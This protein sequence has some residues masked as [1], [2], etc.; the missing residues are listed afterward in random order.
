MRWIAACTFLHLPSPVQAGDERIEIPC[1]YVPGEIHHYRYVEESVDERRTGTK[2]RTTQTDVTIEVQ[3]YDGTM[4]V[5]HA[6]YGPPTEL[7][8]D[9]NLPDAVTAAFARAV[10]ERP[11]V[12]HYETN[13]GTNGHEIL[14][15]D[16]LVQATL[17]IVD[18][19]WNEMKTKV[20]S[21]PD[22]VREGMVL[23]ATPA[24][25]AKSINEDLAPLFD[26]S[27]GSFFRRRTYESVL[28]NFLGGDPFPARGKFRAVSRGDALLL[29]EEVSL[30][31][32]SGESLVP[33]VSA[34]APSADPEVVAKVPTI[35][36]DMNVTI[37]VLVDATSGWPIR[38][39]R[40]VA[41]AAS[42]PGEDT[43]WS[44]INVESTR[45]DEEQGS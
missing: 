45:L 16:E 24:M 22:T 21:T 6:E 41:I 18:D 15:L 20:P 43:T 29:R 39:S 11:Y 32:I 28:P 33:A 42:A 26:Y 7:N 1:G 9:P 23:S 8:S 31:P 40:E 2:A 27:C 37:E 35:R 3:T 44:S 30:L 25:V 4:S 38:W 5:M 10:L 13:H 14:N 17:Q 36:V 34:V 19:A 12:V